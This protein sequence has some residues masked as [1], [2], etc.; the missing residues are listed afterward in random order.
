MMNPWGRAAL[1][2]LT[3]ILTVF[4]GTF[5]FFYVKYA[6]VIEDK[7]RHGPFANTSML[8]SAPQPVMVGDPATVGELAS[9]LHEAGYSESSTN[10][11]GW[12]HL[13]P[14]AIEVNPGA[15]AYDA[16]GA[17]VKIVGGKVAQIISLRDHTERT[18]YYL[19]PQLITNLFDKKREKRRLVSFGDI[20]KVMVNAVLAAEDKHFFQHAGFDPVGILRAV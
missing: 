2:V 12:Y 8:Y 16:E 9:Y 18:I 13:R 15:E 11:L 7:L 4:V 3:V 10:R 20:P 17:V 1:L 14:D 6:H 19:E 5:T